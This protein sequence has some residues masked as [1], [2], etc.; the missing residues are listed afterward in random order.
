MMHPVM[1]ERVEAEDAFELKLGLDVPDSEV[2]MHLQ[3]EH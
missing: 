1:L 3:R 2:C